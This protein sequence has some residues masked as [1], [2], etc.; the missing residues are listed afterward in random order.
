MTDFKP[1]PLRPRGA[2]RRE[3]LLKASAEVFLEHGYEKAA[4][5][6]IIARSGGS[7]AFVY[8]QFGDKAGLFGAMMADRCVHILKPLVEALPDRGDPKTALTRFGRSFMDVVCGP[9]ALALQRIAMA[10]GHR[11]PDVADAYFASGHDVAFA[12]L[13]EYIQ[14]ISRRP[15]SDV[16]AHRLS[17]T[18]FAMVQG[19]AV[20]RLV[21]GSSTVVAQTE[22]DAIIDLSVDWLLGC[23]GLDP[24]ASTMP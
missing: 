16:Q 8:E 19:D 5:S 18:F 7:K 3:A 21:V 14:S 22:W 20:Q 13:S 24:T 10:E 11:N 15:L 17:V 12:K 4:L 2:V 9:Q 23:L 6:E 1:R